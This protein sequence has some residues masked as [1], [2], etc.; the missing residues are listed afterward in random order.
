LARYTPIRNTSIPEVL[1]HDDAYFVKQQGATTEYLSALEQM[2]HQPDDARVKAERAAASAARY[3]RE[4]HVKK[5]LEL[6]FTHGA[7]TAD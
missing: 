1:T 5:M 2:S 7:V 4:K 3:R 6:L